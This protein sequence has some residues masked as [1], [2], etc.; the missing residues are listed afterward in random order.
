VHGVDRQQGQP[1]AGAGGDVGLVHAAPHGLVVRGGD[2]GRG[3]THDNGAGAGLRRVDPHAAVDAAA[4]VEV[5]DRVVAAAGEQEPVLV[6]P[7]GVPRAGI[8]LN[9]V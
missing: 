4:A 5:D 3:V 2:H 6:E 8:V 9:D 7:S 1:P